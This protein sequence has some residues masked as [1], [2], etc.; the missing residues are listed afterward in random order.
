MKRTTYIILTVIAV[1]F[2]LSYVLGRQME[3]RNNIPTYS[4][5]YQK[6][7]KKKLPKFSHIVI[8]DH[9]NE[10][11]KG[12]IRLSNNS[13]M[14][15]NIEISYVSG[16]KDN[17]IEMPQNIMD[18]SRFNLHGDTL[19]I[20]LGCPK[21]FAENLYKKIGSNEKPNKIERYRTLVDGRL[22]ELHSDGYIV[23]KKYKIE[24]KISKNFSSI[25]NESEIGTSFNKIRQDSLNVSTINRS[26]FFSCDFEKLNFTNRR[27]GSNINLEN[28]N[29]R[30]LH[31][32]IN[33]GR[34]CYISNSS[35][36]VDECFLEGTPDENNTVSLP[37]LNYKHPFTIHWIPKGNTGK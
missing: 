7:V 15:N 33:E 6:N 20:E 24:M 21:N 12:Y 19:Y 18:N 10:W 1:L 17:E 32:P 14:D 11:Y 35:N 30:K 27:I 13:N 23:Y 3:A 34:L 29:V 37:S 25:N 31:L 26:Y 22:Y 4:I 5:E 28:T 2:I 8:K 36:R 16:L 9:F